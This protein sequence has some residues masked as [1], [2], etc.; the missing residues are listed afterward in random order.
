M[1][2]SENFNP[3]IYELHLR[4]VLG[5]PFH[6][7]AQETM[8]SFLAGRDAS[9]SQLGPLPKVLGSHLGYGDIERV[10]NPPDY[11]LNYSPFVLEGA[12]PR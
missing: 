10:L 5:Y 9:H 6:H 2:S 1:I 4:V 8:G 7:A 3:V 12:V 11:G